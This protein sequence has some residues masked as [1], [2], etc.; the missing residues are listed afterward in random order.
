MLVKIYRYRVRPE[1]ADAF[2]ELQK[3]A[4]QIYRRH[5]SFKVS[6]FRSQADPAAWTEVHWYRDLD[7]ASKADRLMVAE[8]E[9]KRLFDEFLK[10]LD[11]KDSTIHEELLDDL[12]IRPH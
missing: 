6:H 2:L 10:M 4:D 3:Q 5:V 1:L 7:T 8:P 9:L 11:P 12:S